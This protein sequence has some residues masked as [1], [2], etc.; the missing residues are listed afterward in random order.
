M[1]TPTQAKMLDERPS[2]P[3]SITKNPY[4]SNFHHRAVG[5]HRFSTPRSLWHRGR[6]GDTHAHT[7]H[8]S[9]TVTK[10]P[11]A[12]TCGLGKLA[13]Q[14]IS[15]QNRIIPTSAASTKPPESKTVQNEQNRADPS[16]PPLGKPVQMQAQ[17]CC[18]RHKAT[19]QVH[20]YQ[21]PAT[22][23]TTID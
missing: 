7:G 13:S 8:I 16:C 15:R 4:L 22:E 18:A 1:E 12:T 5:A 14:P 21:H 6:S 20:C 11:T 9:K 19:M 3:L 17:L 2:N 10:V 23:K